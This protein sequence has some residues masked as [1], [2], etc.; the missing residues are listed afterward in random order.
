M[1]MLVA[2][3]IVVLTACASLQ[4]EPLAQPSGFVRG[5]LVLKN[6]GKIDGYIKWSAARKKYIAIPLSQA[7]HYSISDV[8]GLDVHKDKAK[9]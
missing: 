3:L 4:A 8:Q 1:R 6:G 7:K 5:T 9:K 2:S